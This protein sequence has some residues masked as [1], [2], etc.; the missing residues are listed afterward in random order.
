MIRV[1]FFVWFLNK[2]NMGLFIVI[3]YVNY[4]LKV[5]YIF[6][7]KFY[8]CIVLGYILELVNYEEDNCC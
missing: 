3:Y 1:S 4:D 8:E 6:I 7:R 2:L 5:C